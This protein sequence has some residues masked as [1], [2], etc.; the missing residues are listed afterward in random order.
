MRVKGNSKQIISNI[1]W[2]TFDKVFILILNLLVTVKVANHFGAADY[3]TYQYAASIVAIFEILVT[4]VDSR[5]VKKFYVNKD[6][7]IVVRSATLSR[8]LFSAISF[9]IGIIVIII[10]NRD[11]S[12]SIM[13]LL[14]LFNAVLTN[15]RFGM[16]SRFEYLLKSKKVVIAADLASLI[17]TFLQLGAVELELS[18][19]SISVIAAISSL[20]NLAVLFFQYRVEFKEEKDKPVKADLKLVKGMIR[21]SV[22]LAIA[23]SCATIYTKCDSVMLGSMMTVAQVGV[24]SISVKIISVVQIALRPIRE[25][26]YPNLLQLYAKDKEKYEKKYIQISSA[27][28]WIYICGVALS[29]IVLPIMFNF[30]NE[31]YME[32]FPVYQILVIGTF[33]MFNA[34]LRAGHFTMIN[35]GSILMWSQIISV[36]VN[37]CLNYVG[38]KLFGIYGAAF[39]TAITQWISLF[40]SNLFFGKEGREVFMWQLKALN[41]LKVIGM[42]KERPK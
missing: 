26:V 22:P 1:G 31:E 16:S 10:L 41:P 37:I 34:G 18:I 42:L 25:S 36:V 40:I 33:F 2:M 5:V 17:G 29:F 7:A 9:F 13:F 27:L 3:G 19:I 24:Y 4:F 39:A 20:I 8:V 11:S 6:S 30:L 32:A 23:A 28:T 12:F 38:I 14:L 35:K 15:L 21:E